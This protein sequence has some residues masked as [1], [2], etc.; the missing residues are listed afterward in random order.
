M[1]TD[2][3]DLLYSD[4]EDDLR[5]AVRDLLAD[6][7]PASA[8][9]ARCDSDTPYDLELWRTLQVQLGLAGLL[10]PEEFGGEGGSAREVG[11]VL[12]ELAA[13]VAPVPFLGS[14]VL[15]T[16]A[17]LGCDTADGQVAALLGR[18]ASGESTA[19]LAVPLSAAPGGAFPQGVEADAHGALSGRVT[20]V[21][22]ATVADVL[23]V[24]AVGSE[25]PGLY[26]VASDAPGVRISAATPLDLTR[27]IADVELAGVRATRLAAGRI[28]EA[29]VDRALL[30]GAGLLASEQV[31]VAQWCL[32]ETVDY[33]GQRRQFGRV[34]GSFQALKHRL[35]DIWLEVV[36]AR[37]AARAAADALAHGAPDTAVLVHVA[38]AY[39]A[40]VAVHAAEECVQL[41]GGIGM[42]W[43][44]PAHL[45]L[46]RAKSS[47]I[48]LGTPG[49]HRAALAALVDLPPAAQAT[50]RPAVTA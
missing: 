22:D 45:R 47:E 17:L 13:A 23:L 40:P 35:A 41:H 30:A 27:P 36:S 46:K 3:L 16:S 5:A 37:A 14:A 1:N 21:A 50:G 42:T 2:G 10:V 39:C 34:V 48:A 44:H 32:D 25:G 20:S 24:P 43:E 7:C 19:A 31:G 4:V 26:E 12:E 38:Q 8:V 29:A 28:A 9:L 49:R 11:V 18:L 15:A 33:L 6:R